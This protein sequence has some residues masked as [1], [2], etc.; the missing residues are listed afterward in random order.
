MLKAIWATLIDPLETLPFRRRPRDLTISRPDQEEEKEAVNT[1][2]IHQHK[3]CVHKNCRPGAVGLVASSD[4]T[5]RVRC[6]QLCVNCVTCLN[7]Q[8]T[9]IGTTCLFPIHLVPCCT[10]AYIYSGVK[11]ASRALLRLKAVKHIT[12][13]RNPHFPSQVPKGSDL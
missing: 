7:S 3:S 6:I 2:G 13:H 11:H 8:H 9:K 12:A 10:G 1:D 4:D 5:Q